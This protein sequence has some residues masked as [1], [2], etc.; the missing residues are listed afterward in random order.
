M[1][2]MPVNKKEKIVYTFLMV[3][4]M[5]VVMTTYNVFLH[6]GFSI[7]G[8]KNA[9]MMF[10]LTFLTAFIVEW[11]IIAPLAFRTAA[12]FLKKDD[13]EI[14]KGL[15]TALCFVSGMVISMSLYGSILMNG[16]SAAT[17]PVWGKN[18]CYNF[19]LAFPLQVFI[20]RPLIGTIF[21]ELFPVG[22]IIDI[23]MSK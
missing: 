15:V 6:E 13:P 16:L 23:K 10:P 1:N 19:I 7:G 22:T 3:I 18:I 4:F 14:K 8:V 12:R 17:L 2:K 5:V 11:F 9:W 21:R 20:A